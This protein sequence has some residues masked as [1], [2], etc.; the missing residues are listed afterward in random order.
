MLLEDAGK[1]KENAKEK[2]ERNQ[3]QTFR[4]CLSRNTF[5]TLL[6]PLTL[7]TLLRHLP[8]V[9]IKLLTDPRF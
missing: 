7:R 4:I 5:V 8:R 2:K 9:K 3:R 1:N 6:R